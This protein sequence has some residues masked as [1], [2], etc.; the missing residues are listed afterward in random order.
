MRS[1][2]STMAYVSSKRV[3]SRARR[4]SNPM[5]HATP[6]GQA[7]VGGMVSLMMGIRA[8]GSILT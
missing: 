6:A 4:F 2:E 3:F 8:R 7:G 1:L 5:S